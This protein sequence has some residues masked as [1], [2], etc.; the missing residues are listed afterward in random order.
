[1]KKVALIFASDCRCLVPVFTIPAIH[2]LVRLTLH[3]GFDPI[4]IVGGGEALRLSLGELLPSTSLISPEEGETLKHLI[5]GQGVTGDTRVLA[6]SAHTVVDRRSLLQLLEKGESSGV[7]I[8]QGRVW[9]SSG[10]IF[11]GNFADLLP[12]L[13]SLRNGS[14]CPDPGGAAHKIQGFAGLPKELEDTQES[15]G[16]AEEALISALSY[17][18]EADDGFFARHFDRRISRF[19]SRRLAHTAMTPNQI[20]LV[21]VCI[22]LAGAYLLS[23]N[24]YWS[25][26]FGALLFLFCVVVDGVDGEVAR[27]KL[28]ESV[29]GHYLDIITDNVVHVA[30][31]IGIAFGLYH[32]SGDSGYL[33]A[34]WWMLGGFGLC[35][36]AVYQCILRKSP[37]ELDRSPRLVRFLALLSNRDFAYL[38]ALLALLQRLD[39]FLLGAA[40]GTYLFAGT[41]WM[42][43]FYEARQPAPKAP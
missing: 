5:A 35:I 43:N 29:F 11:L 38:V 41:L 24:G 16:G 26:L 9:N 27:L 23:M 31:F 12:L 22:G 20:T 30:V 10:S 2:R 19:F 28:Q 13:D 18:T 42:L 17:Q 7:H 1:M 4:L 36:V 6:M 25:K 34:L 40:A 32:D 8:L 14:P 33:L 37:E 15:A 21:G 39:W 3:R